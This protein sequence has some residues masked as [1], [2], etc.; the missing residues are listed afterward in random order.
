MAVADAVE[1]PLERTDVAL[2]GPQ[3][4]R[5]VRLEDEFDGIALPQSQALAHLKRNRRLA[6][7]RKS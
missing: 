4:D 7:A 3:P 1:Q 2:R 6:L 5:A